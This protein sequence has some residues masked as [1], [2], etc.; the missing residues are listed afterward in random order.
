[1]RD[2]NFEDFKQWYK[3]R[4]MFDNVDNFLN[5]YKDNRPETIYLV[6]N[7]QR[8]YEVLSAIS[9]ICSFALE[10]N[11]DGTKITTNPDEL[12]GTSLCVE[13]ITPLVVF[14]SMQE[15]CAA[16]SSADNLEICARTDG[17]VLIGIVFEDVYD[18]APPAKQ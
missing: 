5:W 16:L 8:Y 6:K 10:S 14:E 11:P 18:F 7:K 13:I 12:L 17:T 2:K 3:N 1:M 15:L 4:K 9:T